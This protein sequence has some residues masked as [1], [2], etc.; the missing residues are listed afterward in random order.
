MAASALRIR[1][2]TL[3]ASRGHSAMPMLTV[4]NTSCWL[5]WNGAPA[6]SSTVRASCETCSLRLLRVAAQAVDEQRKLIARQA[7]QHRLAAQHPRQPLGQRLEHAVARGVAEGVV[8]FL[9]MVHVDVQQRH[10]LADAARPRDR[11][12][13][14][15]LE[16]HAVGDLGERVVA[17]QVADAALGALAFGDVARH[18]DVAGELRVGA[19][20][21]GDHERHRYGLARRGCAAPSRPHRGRPPADRRRPRRPL[22]AA[23]RRACRSV[24]R[25]ANPVMRRAASLTRRITPSGAATNTLSLMLLSTLSQVVAAVGGVVQGHAR[26]FERALQ[27]A[28][29]AGQAAVRGLRKFPASQTL[30]RADELLDAILQALAFAPGPER[31]RRGPGERQQSAPARSSVPGSSGRTTAIATQPPNAS[32]RDSAATCRLVSCRLRTRLPCLA[33]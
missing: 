25:T 21:R 27:P 11:L 9:E 30:E 29:V 12:L 19:G 2:M 32:A 24:P 16:L 1:S 18:V 23:P 8:D 6:V 5:M 15:V 10:A 22:P 28:Q 17:R 7:P 4:R 3:S 13:Q 33:A 26:A 14:Q 31:G 20:H